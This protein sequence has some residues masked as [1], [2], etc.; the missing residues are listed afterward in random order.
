[1]RLVIPYIDTPLPADVKLIH[2]AEFLGVSCEQLPLTRSTTDYARCLRSTP[3]DRD[4]CFVVNPEVMR[5]W[6]GRDTVPPELGRILAERFRYCLVHSPEDDIFHT[7]VVVA[8]SGGSLQAV[9]APQQAITSYDVAL[10]CR[11]VCEAFSG[12]SFGP[13]NP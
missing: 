11:D 5:Q 4:S 1:M 8:L 2:L 9:R 6:L 3:I 10:D 13:I 12:L 7:K